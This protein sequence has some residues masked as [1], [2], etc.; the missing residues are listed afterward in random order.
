MSKNSSQFSKLKMN[1]ELP[2]SP[3]LFCL[4]KRCKVH[5]QLRLLC[6]RLEIVKVH[7]KMIW[8]FVL[9]NKISSIYFVC[10]YRQD[11]FAFL[12]NGSGFNF[13]LVGEAAFSNNGTPTVNDN[14]GFCQVSDFQLT[15]ICQSYYLILVSV[16]GHR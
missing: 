6:L 12:G 16:I 3:P 4:R 13:S 11:W 10:L 14:Y 1:K 7:C 9:F 5:L 2:K 8:L 15:C